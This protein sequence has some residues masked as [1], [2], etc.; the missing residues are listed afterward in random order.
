[1]RSFDD[2]PAQTLIWESI[3]KCAASCTYQIV[4]RDGNINIGTCILILSFL[5]LKGDTKLIPR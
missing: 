1:M 3:G 2:H 5:T 4:T